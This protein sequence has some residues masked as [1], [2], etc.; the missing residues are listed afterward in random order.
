MSETITRLPLTLIQPSADNPRKTSHADALRELA[1]S[2]LAI[3]LQQP[4]VVRPMANSTGYEIV[5]GHRRFAAMQANL[6]DEIDCIIRPYTNAEAAI[7]RL[8]E[9]MER[10]DV[11]W[12]EEAEAMARLITEHG[13]TAEKLAEHTGK[14]LTYVYGRLKLATLHPTVREIFLEHPDW[15]AE[16]ATLVAR[17]ATSLQPQALQRITHTTYGTGDDN[18]VTRTIFS[19]RQARDTLRSGYTLQ[20]NAAPWATNVPMGG[21][22]GC[23]ACPKASHNDKAFADAPAGLCT[24]PECWKAKEA[25]LQQ[26][27]VSAL[28]SQ[29]RVIDLGRSGTDDD[30]DDEANALAADA[31][32]DAAPVLLSQHER[33]TGPGG[34]TFRVSELV[35]QAEDAGIEVPRHAIVRSGES[36]IGLTEEDVAQLVKA[37]AQHHGL[38]DPASSKPAPSRS[39]QDEQQ[40]KRQALLDQLSP[41]QRA[42]AQQE[43]WPA[44]RDAILAAVP[45]SRRCKQDLVALLRE[46]C[47]EGYADELRLREV[48]FGDEVDAQ[49]SAAGG[50]SDEW[51]LNTLIPRMSN[52]QMATLLTMRAIER[53]TAPAIWPHNALVERDRI[54]H[55]LAL[56]TTYG[57]DVLA[58][59]GQPPADEPAADLLSD[60]GPSSGTP[61]GEADVRSGGAPAA[62][63][64]GGGC[65]AGGGTAQQEDQ[66]DEAACGGQEQTDEASASAGHAGATL[67]PQ[68][69]WPFPKLKPGQA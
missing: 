45:T 11:H 49:D 10:E 63:E 37:L 27:Q 55:R 9:N 30:D 61:A 64:G 40:A 22:A 19:Y 57:V 58:L 32:E 33:V 29:G 3:G 42:V 69:A 12:V 47:D 21:L 34:A 8:H 52:D 25:E 26:L 48:G 65:G 51:V 14:K 50:I 41:H 43:S 17:V 36:T 67:T 60:L 15:S 23:H 46:V 31:A 38:A 24:D 18:T 6:V 5:F 56:A 16:T 39:Y 62:T 66:T 68:Q 53:D 35:K 13:Y 28:R 20:I 4:I 59:A 54:A 1:D 44:I 7:A 2:I